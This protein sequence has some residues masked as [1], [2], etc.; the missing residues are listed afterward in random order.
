MSVC[1]DTLCDY[2]ALAASYD[3][4]SLLM[5]ASTYL[6][7][8]RSQIDFATAHLLTHW[9]ECVSTANNGNGSSG[10]T[11]SGMTI[12]SAAG[13]AEPEKVCYGSIATTT[14][15]STSNN[16]SSNSSSSSGGVRVGVWCNLSLK[17]S[18][19][20]QPVEQLMQLATLYSHARNSVIQRCSL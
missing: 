2:T 18:A 9:D 8:K 1:V 17:V 3:S 16:S 5:L 11:G 12:S 7:F 19:H 15:T 4:N 10:A 20:V 14:T 6:V 13:D